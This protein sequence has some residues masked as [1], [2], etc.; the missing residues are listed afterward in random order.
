MIKRKE[1]II[2]LTISVLFFN[3]TLTINDNFKLDFRV[4]K[5]N[6]FSR[7]LTLK[8]Y[9]SCRPNVTIHEHKDLENFYQIDG[10]YIFFQSNSNKL[11]DKFNFENENIYVNPRFTCDLDK[12]LTH[13]PRKKV[14]G[15]TYYGKNKGYIE[16]IGLIAK[17]AKR[18]YPDWVIRIY[19][20]S[21]IDKTV[22]C[23]YE[24]KHDN[25][26]FCNVNRMPYKNETGIDFFTSIV[27]N[28]LAF[29]HGMMW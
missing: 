20:D 2:L 4:E 18:L 5:R 15:Y 28:D 29:I 24:C 26:Y 1:K 17:Q 12:V 6:L 23:N 22:I 9:C 21:S 19:Y 27:L 11:K 8:A 25:V 10:Y 13:G 3:W 16:L 14:L 7:K